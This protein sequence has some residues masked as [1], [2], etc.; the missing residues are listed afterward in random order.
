MFEI[1][2]PSLGESET[3][4]TLIT[5]LKDVGD[6]IHV[7]DILAEIE[8][9]KI[10]MEITATESGKLVEH[11][12]EVEDTV[13]PGQIIGRIDTSF[14]VATQATSA[15]NENQ[16]TP[17]EAPVITTPTPSSETTPEDLPERQ[18]LRE[19][20]SRLRKRIATRLKE[21]QNTAAM[22]T[23]FNE[24]NMQ[25][26]MDVRNTHQ[27]N[28]V[29][30][31]GVKLG[32]M[33]FFSKACAVACSEF[34]NVNAS[35]DGDDVVYHNYIDMG[36]AVSTENGLIV[37]VLRDAGVKSLATIE[38]EIIDL[39]TKAR[40]GG[41]KPDDLHGGTFSITNGGIFGSLLSTPI[42]NMPQS[43]ILG[44]HSIQQRAVVEDDMIVA[45]PMMYLALSYDHRLID[46]KDA[47]QF[48]VRVKAL[49]ENPQSFD[50]NI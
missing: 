7:D 46:G 23:T 20:I 45:R 25:P 29:A 37:P 48:L 3:E 13:E 18:E 39:A 32:F 19:P 38:H 27:E 9:D 40:Q 47:V 42:L 14:E 35:I 4:A 43:A 5:W 1:K 16:A 50:L 33:S 17:E 36:I 8:S 6:E 15:T 26:I 21:A 30:K 41:L 31:H 44:M 22:L 10:T 34:P 2:V 49:L 24:V 28:F 11:L 12:S